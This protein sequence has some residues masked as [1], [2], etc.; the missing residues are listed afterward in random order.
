[1]QELAQRYP[2]AEH[3][4][5]V[6]DNLNTHA[7]GSFYETFPPAAAKALWGRFEFIY[8]PEHGTLAQRGRDRDL[9]GAEESR[10]VPDRLA[11][12]H[13][14]CRSERQGRHDGPRRDG[15]IVG[16]V[17]NAACDIAE[18]G[19]LDTADVSRRP[20]RPVARR[21]S[22]E[23]RAVTCELERVSDRVRRVALRCRGVVL[24]A[25]S[26]DL[27]VRTGVRGREQGAEALSAAS[28]TRSSTGSVVRFLP[29]SARIRTDIRAATVLVGDGELPVI[30]SEGSRPDGGQRVS[31]KLSTSRWKERSCTGP[32]GS[33]TPC[34]ISDLDF[35]GGWDDE[36]DDD[37]DGANEDDDEDGADDPAGDYGEYAA[38]HSPDR[39]NPRADR[40]PVAASLC[41]SASPYES[42]RCRRPWLWPRRRA[43]SRPAAPTTHTC[44]GRSPSR[45]TWSGPW[46]T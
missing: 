19:A 7:P 26:F 28:R 13:R 46:A 41:Q 23:V 2:D 27:P 43:R 15:S 32:S 31:P 4:T 20:A 14:R 44:T 3:I 1:M 25:R 10:R 42:S 45:P 29:R 5:F 40:V 22:P 11:V 39:L 12:H 21:Q 6:M 37:R 30:P 33:W 34:S 36:D 38:R 18:E 16:P 35:R 17:R 9:A 24:T 8:T